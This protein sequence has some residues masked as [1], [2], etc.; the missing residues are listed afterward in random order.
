MLPNRFKKGTRQHPEMDFKTLNR[1]TTHANAV[2]WPGKMRF[3]YCFIYRLS[4]QFSAYKVRD[5]GG[6]TRNT[7][8]VPSSSSE[9]Y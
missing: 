8:T 6:K 5:V 1:G 7:S 2:G 9:M 3:A 4:E